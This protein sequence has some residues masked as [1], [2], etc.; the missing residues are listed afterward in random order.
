MDLHSFVPLQSNLYISEAE[1]TILMHCF[2]SYLIIN[3]F[4]LCVFIQLTLV[5]RRSIKITE[6]VTAI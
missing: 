6:C 4:P 5:A 3:Q 1:V 2:M